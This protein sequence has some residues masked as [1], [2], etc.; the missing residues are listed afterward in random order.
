MR[1]FIF[2]LQIIFESLEF[3]VSDFNLM[4]TSLFNFTEFISGPFKFQI[5]FF[6]FKNFLFNLYSPHYFTPIPCREA[7]YLKFKIE[8]YH[9]NFVS[10]PSYPRGAFQILRISIFT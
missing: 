10:N 4:D 2:H 3:Q 9:S 1:S 7:Y 5:L 8:P 6:E